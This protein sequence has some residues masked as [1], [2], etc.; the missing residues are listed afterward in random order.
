MSQDRLM[1]IAIGEFGRKGLQG[2]STRGIAAAAGTAMS[3]ITYHYG[4]KEGLYHAAA[5]HIAA[6]MAAEMNFDAAPATEDPPA[7]RAA[8]HVLVERFVDKM[9]NDVTADRALFI[10]REQLNPGPAFDRIYAGVMEQMIR[11]LVGFVAVATGRDQRAARIATVT[12]LGQALTV[13]TSRAAMLRL[14]EVAELD[15][16][17]TAT[18]KA[19]IHANIDAILDRMIAEELQ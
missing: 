5:D 19:R 8:I 14:L 10:L 16:E 18:L 17:T 2:A 15:A 6:E 9:A 13:R 1:E 3:A 7:A 11:T 12:L 4:G